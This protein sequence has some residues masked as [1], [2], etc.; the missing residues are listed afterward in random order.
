MRHKIF[1]LRQP[2]QGASD[3]NKFAG[4]PTGERARV[5]ISVIVTITEYCR[6]M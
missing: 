6:N 4:V 3:G 5:V 2:H 1:S